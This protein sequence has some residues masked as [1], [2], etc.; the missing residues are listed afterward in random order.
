MEILGDLYQSI[1]YGTATQR[2]T[3]TLETSTGNIA[4]DG[5]SA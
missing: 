3:F 2:Y 1:N 4:V 5:E